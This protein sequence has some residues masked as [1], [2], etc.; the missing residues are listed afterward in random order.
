M[1]ETETIGR[2][3]QTRCVEGVS[4]AERTR[5]IMMSQVVTIVALLVIWWILRTRRSDDAA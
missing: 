1:T 3:K 5:V 4:A 2:T